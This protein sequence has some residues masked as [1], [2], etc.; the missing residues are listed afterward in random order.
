[1]QTATSCRSFTFPPI[2][3][4]SIPIR[5]ITIRMFREDSSERYSN[6]QALFLVAILF[7]AV[8]SSLTFS[9]QG[10]LYG[11]FSSISSIFNETFT[12]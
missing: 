2:R 9:N 5:S 1:M 6:S 7:Q 3:A 4:T 12:I 10:I 11:Y 8:L